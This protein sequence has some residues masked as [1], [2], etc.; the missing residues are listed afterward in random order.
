LTDVLQL[1]KPVELHDVPKLLIEWS[2]PWRE[3]VTAIRPALARSEAR[4]AG[5]APYGMFPYRGMIPCWLVE[6]FL[7][8]AAIIVPGKLAQLRPYVAPR[9]SSHDVIYYTGDELPRTEDL[10]GAQA[11]VSGQAGGNEAHHRTQT[12]KIARGG[13]LTPKVADA[14]N[15]RLPASGD[16]VANLL[17]IRP[18]PGPPPAEGLRSSRSKPN[19]LAAVVAPAP[20]VIPDYTRNGIA[21]DTVVPPAPNF[22]RDQPL[23]APTLNP[24][25]IPPAPNVLREHTL[26]APALGPAVIP[27]APGVSRDRTQT[28]PSVTASVVAPAPSVPRDQER[29][30][31]SL[32]ASVIPP[33]PGAVSREI[34]SAPVQ[35]T[36][37]AVVPPPVSS[38]ERAATRAPKLALP[39]PSVITPPPSADVSRE[40]NHL[41]SGSVPDPFKAIIPPAPTPSGSGSFVSTLIGKIFGAAEVVPPPPTVNANGTGRGATASLTSNVVPPPPSVS[42]G[43]SA[44][45]TRD[46]TGSALTTNVVPPPPS[47]SAASSGSPHGARNGTGAA[48]ASNVIAPPPSAGMSGA[49]GPHTLAPS[50]APALGPPSIIP[51]PPSLSGPGGGTGNTGG[52]AGVSSGTLANNI[53]PPPPSVGGGSSVTGSGLGRRGAG[54][55]TPLDVGSPAAPPSSGGSGSGAGVVVSSHPGSKLGL[56]TTGGAGALAM[57]PSGGDK[58]GLG[59]SGGG[60]G[61]GR[62]NGP[63]SGTKGEGPGAGKAGPGRGSDPNA[64]G[65]ISPSPGPGG[66]GTA[67]TG[68]SSVPGVSISGGSSQVTIDLGAA[69]DPS[70]PPRSSFKQRETLGVDVVA[71]ATSAGAFAPYKNQLH[72][73]K[74]TSYV[75]TPLGT[76]VMEY[77]DEASAG[78]SYAGP[79][80]APQQVRA[81]LPNGLPHAQM[82]V[83]CVLDASGNLRNLRVLE[84]GSAEMTAKVLAALRSWKFRPALRAGQPVEVTAILGF[85][86][87]T[88]DRF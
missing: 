88:D 71:T 66:A 30:A 41:A 49:T 3:F 7:I 43:G 57:S 5:E 20:N 8:F 14:P 70:V 45:G 10:G 73:E 6:A 59:G 32:A 55:G 35:M 21:L 78:R 87:N 25:V 40:V 15:L 42:A 54:L 17:A 9:F 18:N 69:A 12:I 22:S 50:A 77:A 13:S 68:T 27:P 85:N 38:P 36:N 37:V 65:G 72:G 34:T 75:D 39:A 16:A 58:P 76:V 53:I 1:E 48:L 86:I 19:L 82:I 84:P 61:I 81:D 74:H 31:P 44:H 29:A 56:P 80:T 67:P 64:H 24:N 83:A 33:A 51:P 79:L 60:T 47:L 4:L 11:G 63:G 62:G 52:G 26:V 46:G 28:A 23:T 2:S